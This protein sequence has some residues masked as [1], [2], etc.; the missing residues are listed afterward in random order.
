MVDDEDVATAVER[1]GD[2]HHETSAGVVPITRTMTDVLRLLVQ[3]SEPDPYT[4]EV[5]HSGADLTLSCTCPAGQNNQL[6]KHRTR[7][8]SGSHEGLIQISDQLKIATLTEWLEGSTLEE[9]FREL[10]EAEAA[11]EEATRR[12]KAVRRKFG[13]L[14]EGG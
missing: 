4:V 2:E 7:L 8:L 3:G 9:P 10:V 13:R 6:C 12:R 11:L 1:C 14:I 5:R